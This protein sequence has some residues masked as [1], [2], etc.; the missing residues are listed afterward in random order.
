MDG[1]QRGDDPAVG[2][3]IGV[4][5]ADVVQQRGG[6]DGR[7]R[8]VP[9][10]ALDAASHGMGVATV[11][12]AHPPPQLEL[13]GA[14]HLGHPRLGLGT[15]SPWPQRPEEARR[16]V[17]GDAPAQA[18]RTQKRVAGIASSRGSLIASPQT[19]HTP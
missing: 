2:A 9:E 10:G 18:W 17:G 11:G 13:L 14:E 12:P 15:R 19:S 4:D 7:R 5:L 6:E 8:L 1:A 16:Q 3:E